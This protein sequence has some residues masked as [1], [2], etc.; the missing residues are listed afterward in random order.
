M[1]LYIADFYRVDREHLVYNLS[2]LRILSNLPGV[3]KVVF[4]GHEGQLA[5]IR[6]EYQQAESSKVVFK[7]VKVHQQVGGKHW[8]T[9]LRYEIANTYRL[10]KRAPAG[11]IVYFC[12]LSPVTSLVYKLFKVFFRRQKVFITLHGDIDFIQQN[13]SRLRNYLGRFFIWS[14]QLKDAQTKYMVLS[15]Q[16]R[17]NLI[18]TG[19]LRADEMYA[20]NHPYLFNEQA[21]QKV[22]SQPLRVGHIGLASLEKNT[23]YLFQLA[24]TMRQEVLNKQIEFSI[25]GTATQMDAYQNELVVFDPKSPMLSKAA[26]NERIA[27]L[28]YIVFFYSDDNYRFC[29]SGAILD[30]INHEIPIVSLA[31]EGFKAIFEEA[32]GPIGYLCRDLDE[33]KAL[34]QQ[35]LRDHESPKARENYA[36]M[37]HHLHQLKNNYTLTAVQQQFMDQAKEFIYG[38]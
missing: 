10:L 26:F 31:N 38:K 29:S 28:D 20:I 16:I 32:P 25:I 24:E 34:F 11:S 15:R 33:M 14:F 8:I 1:I 21:Q 6:N 2:M 19:Y 17:S 5:L 30:A 4:L 12:S 18:A 37:S 22:V 35:R 3:E 27:A 9:K 7:P 36:Q 23:Q 13:K